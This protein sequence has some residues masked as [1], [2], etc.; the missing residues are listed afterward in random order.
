[1]KAFR[2]YITEV[3]VFKYYY[4]VTLASNVKK[5]QAKGIVPFQPSN[6]VKGDG[7]RYNQDYAGVYAFSHP[8]DAF[9]WAFKMNWDFKKPTSIVRIK[10]GST[11]RRDP[12]DD[13]HLKMGKGKALM[14]AKA[15]PSS[16]IIDSFPLDYFDKPLDFDKITQQLSESKSTKKHKHDWDVITYNNGHKS[17]SLT[18]R[19]SI[20]KQTRKV[21]PK[22]GS[23]QRR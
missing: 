15:I 18:E 17:Y 13:I 3:K 22:T 19:C 4:H 1:M 21:N 8:E 5:I 12:S 6:W 2:S 9:K 14:S 20:C 16:D 10:R 11:W 23:V 7:S